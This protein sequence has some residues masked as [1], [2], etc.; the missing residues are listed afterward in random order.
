NVGATGPCRLVPFQF[1]TAQGAIL[2]FSATGIG[3]TTIIRIWEPVTPGSWTLGLVLSGGVPIKILAPYLQ[4]ELFQLDCSTQ[5]ADVLWIFHPNYMPLCVERLG[6]SNWQI[7][8]FP[9]GGGPNPYFYRGN[10]D[11]I[12]TSFV[13][14][15]IVSITS[16][17]PCIVQ[18]IT[19]SFNAGNRIYI[20]GCAGITQL[21]GQEFYVITGGTTTALTPATNG[22]VFTGSIAGNTLT[23]TA[24]IGGAISI[25][26]TVA[27]ASAGTVITAFLTGTGGAG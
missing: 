9:P 14:D 8:D 7:V 10:L 6:P 11:S 19:G 26:M 13:D 3:G 4:S 22:A 25:G 20:N 18:F 12:G 15:P 27:G 1:S 16:A 24:I 2:E 17:N 21:N 23:V 5:S